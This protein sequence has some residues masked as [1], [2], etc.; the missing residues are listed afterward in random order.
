MNSYNMLIYRIL[1][2]IVISCIS[3]N[4]F[5]QHYAAKFYSSKD[6]PN[7]NLVYSLLIDNQGSLWIGSYTFGL[8]K[9]DGKDFEGFNQKSGLLTDR[10]TKLVQ[11]NEGAIWAGD[12]EFGYSR[13]KGDKMTLL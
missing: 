13:I 8:T 10:V 3:T 1:L 12:G 4:I 7:I 9:F 11:D 5:S 2:I 6:F